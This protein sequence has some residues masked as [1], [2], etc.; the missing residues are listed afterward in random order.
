MTYVKLKDNENQVYFLWEKYEVASCDGEG[1]GEGLS[2]ET[3]GAAAGCGGACSSE[4]D[5]D[6]ASVMMS[7]DRKL[8]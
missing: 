6:S 8:E 1:E 5:A 2:V 7:P 4:S 3:D